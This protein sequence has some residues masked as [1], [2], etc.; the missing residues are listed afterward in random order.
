MAL[1]IDYSGLL[2]A[3]RRE[4]KVRRK[5]KLQMTEDGRS[6]KLL[7]KL[8]KERILKEQDDLRTETAQP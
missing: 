6:V 3:E 4:K 5:Q 7:D 2:K 8:S 1:K